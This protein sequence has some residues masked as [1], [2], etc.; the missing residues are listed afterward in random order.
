MNE[1]SNVV[2]EGENFS[3][4]ILSREVRSVQQ[5]FEVAV[6]PRVAL[7]IPM[8]LDGQL[9]LIRQFRPAMNRVTLEFPAGRVKQDEDPEHA[10]RREILE[11]IGFRAD[12]IRQLGSLLSAPHF[13][14]EVVDVFIAIGGIASTPTP[15]PKEDLRDVIII[16]P[17]AIDQSIAEGRLIDSKSIA[18]H[19]L[20]RIHSPVFGVTL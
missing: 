7:C 10:A 17:T 9:I 15:T 18:A 6:R 5:Q 12:S 16:P 2:F 3:V 1:S 8:T 4:R 11:E 19:A 14:D 13:S 20:A